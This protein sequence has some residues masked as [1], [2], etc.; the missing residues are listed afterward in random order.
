[1]SIRH[2][3]L[4]LLLMTAC[5]SAPSPVL[6]DAIDDAGVTD[7]ASTADPCAGVVCK[8]APASQCVDSST[9]RS[10]A[11]SGSCVGGLCTYPYIDSSCQNGCQAN[12]CRPVGPCGA[13]TSPPPPKCQDDSTALVYAP[14]GSCVDGACSY[15][16]V[17]DA[18]ANGCAAGIC[19][20]VVVTSC[21]VN[22]TPSSQIGSSVFSGSL[23]TL[24][25]S[26]ATTCLPYTAPGFAWQAPMD[27]VYTFSG[28]VSYDEVDLILGKSYYNQQDDAFVIAGSGS[29]CAGAAFPSCSFPMKRPFTLTL[30][31]GQ[32]VIVAVTS[33]W[34]A[35]SQHVS[36]T[37]S[38]FTVDVS[39]C[40][41]SC[42]GRVCGDDGCGGSCGTCAA[43]DSCSPGGS[44]MCQPNCANRECGGDG[45]GGTCGVC[46]SGTCG[47]LGHCICAPQCSGRMCGPDGCGGTCGSCTGGTSCSN[48]TCVTDPNACDPVGNSGCTPPNGCTVLSGEKTACGLLGSG[49]QG[50]PCSTTANCAGGFACFASVCRKICDRA[51]GDGCSAGSTCNG[52]SGWITYGACT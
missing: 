36:V 38:D 30:T 14:T 52:I 46:T 25:G 49:V 43:G 23:L 22:A 37:R 24:P 2:A 6:P 15:P 41:P 50:S 31:A 47:T 3:S 44:C 5:G 7:D 21:P 1:M 40:K 4:A 11:A 32:Q 45:C 8:Q 9:L 48:G 12:T 20:D 42:L 16:S 13:C 33:T 17:P 27:G 10:Y 26:I 35:S 18:C 29:T 51:T 19:K 39:L 34:A 28:S